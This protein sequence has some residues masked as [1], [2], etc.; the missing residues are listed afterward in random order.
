MLIGAAAATG[1]F[2]VTTQ[3]IFS[4]LVRLLWDSLS[5]I[6]GPLAAAALLLTFVYWVALVT[7]TGA[8]LASHIK[9]MWFHGASA[10]LAGEHHVERAGQ[11]DPGTA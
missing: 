9:V 8:S 3:T 10:H 4:L 11:H 2:L 5:I 7:L 1:L 6:Y